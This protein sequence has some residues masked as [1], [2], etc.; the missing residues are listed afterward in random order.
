MFMNKRMIVAMATL[1]WC[2]CAVH[3]DAH[4][5]ALRQTALRPDVADPAPY[6]RTRSTSYEFAPDGDAS[7]AGAPRMQVADSDVTSQAGGSVRHDR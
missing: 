2:A 3:G 6:G 1:A 4:A 7:P 5:N